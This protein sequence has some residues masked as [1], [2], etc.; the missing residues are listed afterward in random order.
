MLSAAYTQVHFK[1]DFIMEAN[2][3]YP[4]QTVHIFCNTGYLN[5]AEEKADENCHDIVIYNI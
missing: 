1:L 4:D 2:T 3:M 5:L